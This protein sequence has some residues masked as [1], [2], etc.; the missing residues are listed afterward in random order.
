MTT[1]LVEA[2]RRLQYAA[3]SLNYHE[4]CEA[5]GWPRDDYTK[6]KFLDFQAFGRLGSFDD[7]TLNNPV[8]FYER[9]EERYQAERK[10]AEE[11]MREAGLSHDPA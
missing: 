7:S 8:L 10:A 1:P 4:F 6:Q 5:V 3:N 2:L 9:R 11:R